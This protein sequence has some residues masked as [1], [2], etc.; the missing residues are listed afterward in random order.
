MLSRVRWV[1]LCVAYRRKLRTDTV[2]ESRANGDHYGE[3][4]A[5]KRVGFVACSVLALLCLAVLARSNAGRVP[6]TQ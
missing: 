4:V 3:A 2:P 5:I 1:A 6:A